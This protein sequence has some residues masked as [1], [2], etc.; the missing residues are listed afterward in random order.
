MPV[1]APSKNKPTAPTSPPSNGKG[2]GKQASVR[3][4][5]YPRYE[6]LIHVRPTPDAVTGEVIEYLGPITVQMAKEALGWET[7]D[8]YV[9]RRLTEDPSLSEKKLRESDF[10]L[11][12][13]AGNKIR[14]RH[15]TLN[16][17]FDEKWAKKIAQ[18]ILT[19]GYEFNGED[20]ILGVTGLVLSG[21]HRLIGLVLA[22][23]EWVRNGRSYQRYWKD[24]EPFIESVVFVGAREDQAVLQTYDNVK[25]RSLSDTIYTSPIFANKSGAEK[26]RLSVMLD[27]CIDWLWRRLDATSNRFVEHQ[28]HTASLDFLERHEKHMVAAVK[29]VHDL[30]GG[31]EDGLTL[32][33]LGLNA[34]RAAGMLFLMGCSGTDETGAEKYH[35]L[36]SPKQEK[37]LDWSNW[38]KAL[39]FWTEIVEGKDTGRK[40]EKG[41]AVYQLPDWVEPF[42]QALSNLGDENLTGRVSDHEKAAVTALA[43][44]EYVDGNT[45]FD[46]SDITPERTLNR[47]TNTFT[48]D[49][50]GPT[51]GLADKGP[52]QK[53]KE[54][55]EEVRTEEQDAEAIRA[56]RTAK[57]KEIEAHNKT[58]LKAD[59]DKK[60]VPPPS[61]KNAGTLNTNGSKKGKK[62][63]PPPEPVDDSSA[64]DE[65]NLVDDETDESEMTPEEMEA[66]GMDVEEEPAAPA[67]KPKRKAK[68]KK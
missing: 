9:R 24:T 12:D 58:V 47:S 17:P 64:P 42:R 14:C 6:A 45:D 18:D 51:F 37:Q 60:V 36:T 2:K 57:L 4:I 61:P 55:Q 43:W 67:P 33:N 56:A 7:D 27:Q 19:E 3:E 21:Q 39:D 5:V 38:Q 15:N 32:S 48:M 20:I 34:G 63:T 50:G 1:P 8:E 30:D 59:T 26:K 54:Q 22:Y 10:L 28:T 35:A 11:K 29:H 49:D 65:Y 53:Q 25:P 23:E 46:V 13:G 66:A 16:R 40:D 41:K 68:A 44:A 52:P 31:G 62:P